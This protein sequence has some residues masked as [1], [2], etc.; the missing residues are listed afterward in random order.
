MRPWLN[1]RAGYGLSV[2]RPSN[3]LGLL[4]SLSLP[5]Y[6]RTD[7]SGTSNVD[8]TLQNPF[9]TLPTANRFPVVPTIYGGPYTTTNPALSINDANPKFRSPYVQQYGLN[10]QIQIPPTTVAEGVYVG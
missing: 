6:V 8:S 10:V 5:N 3:Q 2:D 4:E 1:I 9:P 7:L